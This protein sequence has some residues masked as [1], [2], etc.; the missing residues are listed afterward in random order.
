VS[1]TLRRARPLLGTLVEIGARGPR[2]Q[3]AID[4]AFAAIAEVQARLSRFEAASDIGRFNA[5]A[6]GA[7]LLVHPH[8]Q[9]VLRAARRL[10]RATQGRFDV[11]L[12]R[13]AAGWQL[14]GARLRKRTAAVTIDLG[15]IGKGYAVDCATEALRAHGCS[16]GWVNAGGDLR[17]FGAPG[18]ALR[19]RDEGAGGVRP[20]ARLQ[21]GACATSRYGAGSRSTLT[22]GDGSMRHL[23]VLAPRCLWA[24][25]LTKVAALE[26]EHP[27]LR[28]FGASA[29]WHPA[30]E[31]P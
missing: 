2:P 22:G 8:T 7:E 3:Q 19:L 12:G 14:V 16:A 13:G 26:R 10:E 1:T 4:A 6:A 27:A 17:T 18:L 24:D 21:D 28:E 29:C 20:W 9:A 15:G 25:A 31:T 30:A 5:A 11:T 23:S